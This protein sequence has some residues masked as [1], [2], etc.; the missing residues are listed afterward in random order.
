MWMFMNFEGQKFSQASREQFGYVLLRVYQ[1]FREDFMRG[2]YG[3]VVY[4]WRFFFWGSVVVVGFQSRYFLCFR[5]IW[6]FFKRGLFQGLGCIGA[7][8]FF[9]FSFSCQGLFILN[10]FCVKFI[11]GRGQIFFRKGR[12]MGVFELFLLGFFR[13]FGQ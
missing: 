5:V 10:F 8:F 4:C 1:V 9:C 12:Y 7:C 6:V 13:Q 2:F 11:Q 3:G